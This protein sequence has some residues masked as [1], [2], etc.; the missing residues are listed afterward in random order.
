M[1]S[2]VSAGKFSIPQISALPL[3]LSLAFGSL[4]AQA[5]VTDT[6]VPTKTQAF[7]HL[8]Q[9]NTRTG[10]QSATQAA[11][12]M[13]VEVAKGEAVHV[14]LSLNLRNEEQ[15]D[16]FLQE[17]HEPGSASYGKFLTPEQFA[18]QY[19]PTE[20]Q[21]AEVVAHLRK[22]GF[23]NINVAKNRQL[24]SA[25]G[26]AATVETGFR[27][28]LKSF[29]HEGRRVYANTAAAQVPP[30]LGNIVGSVLGL[31]NVEI[32]HTHH[33][34]I[35]PVAEAEHEVGSTLEARMLAK[36]A[37]PG[38]PVPHDPVEFSKLYNA[39]NTPTAAHTTVG[40]ISAGSLDQTILDLGKFTSDNKLATVHTSVVH[41]GPANSDYSDTSGAVEWNL[42]SQSIVGAAGGAVKQLVFYVAPTLDN[43]AV[44]AAYNQAVIDNMARVINVSLGECE[45]AANGDGT[46][47]A[48]DK[49][50]KQAV[51][52]GQ[53]FS[54]STGDAGPY[55]CSVTSD[56]TNNQ[57]GVPNKA[58]YD[59]SE[60][61]SS[62][63]VIAVGGTT[64]LTDAKGGYSGET[65]WNEGLDQT[66]DPAK[67]ERLWATGGG[68][69]QFEKTPAWQRK[70]TK[71]PTRGLPDIAF[72]AAGSSGAKIFIT[73]K[74]KD[75]TTRS[76]YGVV[77]GT[78]LAA[79]IFSGIWARLQSAH[80]NQLAF[81]AAHFYQYL[82]HHPELVH[83]VTSG[84][85]GS[86]GYGY[87]AAKGWDAAT[88]FGSLDISKLNT[89]IQ[90]TRGFAHP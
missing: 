35:A 44:T 90:K 56:A 22:A 80:G 86:G 14:V 23:V 8:V 62:P 61:A 82:P 3:A 41:T 85:N 40:I 2:K 34:L 42:D 10:P 83:D 81:P 21:V 58:T 49:I 4:A 27:T 47:A 6:W 88:G 7:L 11:A 19:A 77:G 68:F 36:A 26:T 20:K 63:Y 66:G 38:K 74:A 84:I 33:H 31:Q 78:S 59:V 50:F 32:N 16:Q 12:K 25:D 53:T 67:P 76:G 71:K 54:I 43:Q 30:A 28:T 65:V 69:S 52:Q 89:F 15:L 24:V 70:T 46:Q 75:G 64:L 48:D 1:K 55:N 37:D 72:D 51:A 87:K 57:P 9:A 60:P 29:V 79:P 13:A 73:M 39:G 17:L 5:A 18:E 45:A